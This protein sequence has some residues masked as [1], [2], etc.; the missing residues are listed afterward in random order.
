MHVIFFE[1]KN[2]ENLYPIAL[3]RSPFS[4]L[5][6]GTTLYDVVKHNFQPDGISSIVRPY[7]KKYVEKHYPDSKRPAHS[8]LL[9]NSSVVP[10]IKK[11]N[12]LFALLSKKKSFLLKS[13]G[14]TAAAYISSQ[15]FDVDISEVKKLKTEEISDF[16]RELKLPVRKADLDIF[17]NVW[18]IP[19][20][21]KNIIASNLDFLKN[22]YKEYKKGVFIGKDVKLEEGVVFNTEDGPIILQDNTKICSHT[23]LRGPL[24]IGTGSQVNSFA[25]LKDGTSIGPVC[26]IGGEVEAS[27]IQGYSN[28]QHFGFLGHVYVGEWVNMGAGTTN[29]DLK[30]TY[31]EIKMYGQATGQKFLGCVIGDFSKT[32]INTSIY[33]AKGIGVSSFVYGTVTKDVPSFCNHLAQ[34]EPLVEL[35]VEVAQK[36]QAAMFERRKVKQTAIDKKLLEDIFSLTAEWRKKAGVKKGKPKF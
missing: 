15:E 12:S 31:G 34:Y 5:C 24:F 32:A 8:V 27:V 1:D 21:N 10:D 33:T 22:D 30:T 3:T 28:K 26:K 2:I 9:L 18:D 29:S 14:A 19:V 20:Y 35:P 23:V 17:R 25:E 36:V 13:E 4:I 7:I 16:L 6:G 11:L